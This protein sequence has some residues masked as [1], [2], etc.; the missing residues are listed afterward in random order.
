MTDTAEASEPARPD[1]PTT[2]VLLILSIVIA[3]G[4]P[5]FAIGRITAPASSGGTAAHCVDVKKSEHE[6]KDVK[7][8]ANDTAAIQQ[9]V[10]NVMNLVI[11]NPDCYSPA[12]RAQA[13]TTLDQLT[14]NANAAAVANAAESIRECAD[15]VGFGC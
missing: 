9:V 2:R 5:S 14:Q 1:S 8:S 3:A 10:R 11:Q 4:L 15:G 7:V 6:L 12:L 13:Q